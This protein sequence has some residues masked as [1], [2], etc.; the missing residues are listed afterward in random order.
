MVKTSN[1]LKQKTKQKKKTPTTA[2]HFIT[3][4]L[5]FL[6]VTLGAGAEL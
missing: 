3:R 1:L 5:H 4:A 6:S 2:H